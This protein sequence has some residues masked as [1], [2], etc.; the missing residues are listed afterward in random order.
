MGLIK[1]NFWFFFKKK[2]LIYYLLRKKTKLKPIPFVLKFNFIN[3]L[4]VKIE[5]NLALA[6][7]NSNQV[8]FLETDEQSVEVNFLLETPKIFIQHRG[9]NQKKK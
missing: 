4:L 1:K 6:D 2:V 7:F 9:H 8:N 3:F 5:A